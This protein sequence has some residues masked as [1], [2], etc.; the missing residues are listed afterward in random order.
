MVASGLGYEDEG[1]AGITVELMS[2]DERSALDL[3]EECLGGIGSSFGGT[4]TTNS[5]SG[6]QGLGQD[7][8][9][10][11]NLVEESESDF[12]SST[13]TTVSYSRTGTF[14]LMHNKKEKEASPN[15]KYNSGKDTQKSLPCTFCVDNV[16][17][18]YFFLFCSQSRDRFWCCRPSGGE[19]A[20]DAQ[21]EA[22]PD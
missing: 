18:L 13:T 4:S 5:T 16:L 14:K 10:L 19:T 3:S 8:V 1:E 15:E 22:L 21:R 12:Q 20:A 2:P 7:M 17:F 6:S 9:T 11:R